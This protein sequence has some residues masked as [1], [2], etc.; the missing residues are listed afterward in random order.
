MCQA[1]SNSLIDMTYFIIIIIITIIIII[2]ITSSTVLLFIIITV[3][4][5]NRGEGT[6]QSQLHREEPGP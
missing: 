3:I 2:M 6:S 4:V 1:H 5:V